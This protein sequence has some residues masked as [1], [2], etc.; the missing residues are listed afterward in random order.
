[1]TPERS[2]THRCFTRGFEYSNTHSNVSWE[3]LAFACDPDTHT[4]SCFPTSSHAGPP[5]CDA[6]PSSLSCQVATSFL[7]NIAKMSPSLWKLPQALPCPSPANTNLSASE[8]QLWEDLSICL[9]HCNLY[10]SVDLCAGCLIIWGGSTTWWLR[11]SLFLSRL[12]FLI[13]A[14]VQSLSHVRLFVT[15]WTT[16]RQ[17]SLSIT[18]SWSLLKF[19]S[20]KSVMP[21]N[22]LSHHYT[23]PVLQ[24]IIEVQSWK[25]SYSSNLS[26]L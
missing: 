5:A 9:L 17:S 20:I 6:R 7:Q 22:H 8:I 23:L 13:D 10:W 18:N 1:M 4:G 25:R 15:P 21:F 14:L 26:L 24:I 2:G 11:L 12:S 16:A 19:V 3:R